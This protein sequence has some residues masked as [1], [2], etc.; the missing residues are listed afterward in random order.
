MIKWKQ[1]EKVDFFRKNLR[2]NLNEVFDFESNC[3]IFD[4]LYLPTY[5]T[6][7]NKKITQKNFCVGCSWRTKFR[8]SNR[9]TS[10][11]NG[12][13]ESK[14]PPFDSES[15]T[16]SNC[17]FRFFSKKSTFPL[18]FRLNNRNFLWVKKHFVAKLSEKSFKRLIWI[19]VPE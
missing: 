19:F 7:W 16:T 4:F 15:K 11:P 17:I 12:A 2:V 1:S 8:F 3:G 5:S 6:N 10:Q 9:H 18:F 13:R 14:M